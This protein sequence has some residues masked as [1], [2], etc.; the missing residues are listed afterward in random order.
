MI[1]LPMSR[2]N[3]SS[4]RRHNSRAWY[5]NEPWVVLMH[6]VTISGFR[7]GEDTSGWY[8]LYYGYLRVSLETTPALA[9]TVLVDEH[10]NMTSSP[11][12]GLL[13]R[14]SWTARVMRAA[15]NYSP[16]QHE[17]IKY[18]I[19]IT[20]VELLFLW[21]IS[22]LDEHRVKMCYIYVVRMQNTYLYNNIR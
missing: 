22:K 3:R 15:V 11:D 2:M 9:P 6:E 8:I 5:N 10:W 7:G 13:Y 20:N 16:G 12:H 1:L 18:V 17:H 21:N 4:S 14:E 19:T